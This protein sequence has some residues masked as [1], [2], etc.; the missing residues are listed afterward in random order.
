MIFTVAAMSA[1]NDTEQTL[2]QQ[3]DAVGQQVNAAQNGGD[4]TLADLYVLLTE[5]A[6]LR[7][8]VERLEGE[9]TALLTQI[10]SYEAQLTTLR[11]ANIQAQIDE[12]IKQIAALESGNAELQQ[13]LE[14]LQK[15]LARLKG[16]NLLVETKFPNIVRQ[17]E[18][19]DVIITIT[20][21]SNYPIR[22]GSTLRPWETNLP[23]LRDI[24]KQASNYRI[25]HPAFDARPTEI[26]MNPVFDI[27]D[28]IPGIYL[29]P[30]ETRIR[31]WTL[32]FPFAIYGNAIRNYYPPQ[33]IYNVYLSNGTV[34][35]NAITINQEQE[36][37]N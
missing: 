8:E 12:L 5:L 4:A 35:R 30:N 3:V 11:I 24:R 16:I 36:D 34:Y 23:Y 1:C 9:N 28:F 33:G 7:T 6:R 22:I 29:Q 32:D 27:Y 10:A 26:D 37:F 15:E 2:Q 18:S 25:W 17:G 13:K 21:I 20:N 31:R 14:A 19:F